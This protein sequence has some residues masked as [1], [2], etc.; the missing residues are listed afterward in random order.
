M[1]EDWGLENGSD[2]AT[3]L[4]TTEAQGKQMEPESQDKHVMKFK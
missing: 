3:E 2:N 1:R 4:L